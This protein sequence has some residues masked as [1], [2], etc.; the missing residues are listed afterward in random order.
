M[1]LAPVISTAWKADIDRSR[2]SPEHAAIHDDAEGLR[3]FVAEG[4]S[5]NAQNKYG[6]SL[7]YIAPREGGI[8]VA[9]LL[10]REGA[11]VDVKDHNGDTALFHAACTN[12]LEVV[13]ILPVAGAIHLQQ[14]VIAKRPDPAFD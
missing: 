5:V 12:R 9:W 4:L 2:T 8:D 3:E 7:P 11:L 13:K 6:Q 1:V 10:L 14:S